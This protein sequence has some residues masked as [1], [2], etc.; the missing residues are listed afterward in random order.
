MLRSAMAASLLFV[1]FAANPV[2][3][4]DVAEYVSADAFFGN[5]IAIFD[6]LMAS[7]ATAAQNLTSLMV[8]APDFMTEVSN[9]FDRLSQTGFSAGSM[10]LL[11][12]F[13]LGLGAMAE[14]A[15]R[16]VLRKIRSDPDPEHPV[17]F[18]QRLGW[19]GGNL[20]GLC[21]FAL[22][23]GW[24][25][26][27]ATQT[28]LV[29]QT[30]V[31]T[32]LSAILAVRGFAI[33]LRMLI[34]PFRPE[35]R[36]AHLNN[37]DARQLYFHALFIASFAVVSFVTASLF[38]SGGMAQAA[39]LLFVLM[40]RSLVA[41]LVVLAFFANQKGVARLIQTRPDG[42][43]RTGGWPSFAR[44]WH[45]LATIYVG[46]S[47]FVA[48]VLLLLGRT[49]ANELAVLS[50]L[51][52]MGL[53]AISLLLDDW[54]S[55]VDMRNRDPDQPNLP[56]FAQFFARLGRAA[57]MIATII[58]LIRIW[59]APWG[60]A[61]ITS[62]VSQGVVP[63][64]TQMVITFFM[65]YVLWQLVLI[66]SER[67]MSR[68]TPAD[69]A[70]NTARQ[71]RIT[72]LLPLV[73]NFMLVAIAIIAVMIGLS[74]IGV[75][76]LPLFAGAGVIGLAIGLGSQTLVKD[77]VSGIFFLLDDAFRVGDYVDAGVAMGTIER[78]GIRS[79]QIRHHLG[80]LHTVPF[81]EIKTIANHSRDWVIFKMD[82]RLPFETDTNALRKK[83]KALGQKLLLDETF[84][85]LFVEPLKSSGVVMMDD[86]AMVVRA[87]FKSRPGEQF[88]LRRV[89]YEAVRNMFREE[90][91]DV[92]V[93]EV[94]VR[95]TSSDALSGAG[96]Q[97]ASEAALKQS[98]DT[99]DMP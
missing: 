49:E 24:P 78:A 7:S 98:K 94:R 68:A 16:L 21:I 43:Y 99:K 13:W 86:S 88:Q 3:A 17:I 54:A 38:H 26:L 73:R 31:V 71:T 47:W 28:E 36:I 69:G 62:R 20:I 55:R 95:S 14:Q 50:F 80:A 66:G 5:T 91:I 4:E 92:A 53:L 37:E 9:F 51:A 85:G 72:T 70:G 90:G 63:A 30:V 59:S 45:L 82:F 79:L 58:L 1:L 96:A 8:S 84:G 89:V 32:Y 46:M 61:N 11:A 93:R 52:L 56:S 42:T 23:G 64:L 12:V 44:I 10:I 81:G 48:C 75:D 15:Y 60:G 74:A 19:F 25:L 39:V 83:F 29:S 97:I 41:C 35:M 40:T 57:A 67:V 77:V 65:A 22:V 18:G 87:S 6:L 34:S 33:T 27:M 76:V 2:L